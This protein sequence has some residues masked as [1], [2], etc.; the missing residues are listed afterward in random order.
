MDT[1]TEFKA[2]ILQYVLSIKDLGDVEKYL[3]VSIKRDEETFT[4]H[5]N[6]IDYINEF[7]RSFLVKEL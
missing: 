4:I 2:N 1:I 6:Q 7:V 3:G 5:L